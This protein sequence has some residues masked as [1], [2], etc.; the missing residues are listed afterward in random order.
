MGV[1]K[2]QVKHKIL[3]QENYNTDDAHQTQLMNMYTIY[4]QSRVQVSAGPVNLLNI[5]HSNRLLDCKS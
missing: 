2:S 1:L 4:L 5:Y 3:R